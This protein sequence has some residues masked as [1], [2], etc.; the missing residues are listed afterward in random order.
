MGSEM[1]RTSIAQSTENK[2]YGLPVIS[3]SYLR[4]SKYGAREAGGPRDGPTFSKRTKKT[5]KNVD[6][7]RV[8]FGRGSAVFVC[9]CCLVTKQT[10]R[11]SDI[12]PWSHSGFKD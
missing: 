12:N 2:R 9:L 3:I 1:D 10:S 5:H 7:Q 6:G 11:L 4:F 8:H